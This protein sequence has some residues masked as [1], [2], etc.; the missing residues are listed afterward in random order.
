MFSVCLEQDL[1]VYMLVV[2]IVST[3]LRHSMCWVVVVC[4]ER[5]PLLVSGKGRVVARLV[6]DAGPEGVGMV[7]GVLQESSTDGVNLPR[8]Q[9]QIFAVIRAEMAYEGPSC[10]FASE[11]RF[12]PILELRG[13][14][15][16][17][18]VVD[19]YFQSVVYENPS[20]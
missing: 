20:V 4:R 3:V 10:L 13:N 1:S 7:D 14:S 6:H 15:I 5:M 18:L 17:N 2:R 11:L 12:L 16:T 8:I 9:S 19:A